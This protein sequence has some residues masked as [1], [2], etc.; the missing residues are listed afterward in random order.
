MC[1]YRA[2]TVKMKRTSRPIGESIS[3]WACERHSAR[4][5]VRR[6]GSAHSRHL[7]YIG[8][9]AYVIDYGMVR[10]RHA[11][12]L[13]GWRSQPRLECGLSVQ[14]LARSGDYVARGAPR[15]RL[16]IVPTFARRQVTGDAAARCGS[17]NTK[18][19]TLCPRIGPIRRARGQPWPTLRVF[20]LRDV[21]T[22]Y[23]VCWSR[24]AA[25]Q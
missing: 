23:L 9:V 16:N 1:D 17:T 22:L 6:L 25:P 7:R 19:C 11:P 15:T 3:G 12:F 10:A 5:T 4:K 24:L 18:S 20:D 2:P 21:R 13:A 14:E 8:T